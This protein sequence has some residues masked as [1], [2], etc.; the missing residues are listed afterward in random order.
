MKYL[1]YDVTAGAGD[2][3]VVTLSHAANVRLLDSTNFQQFRRGKRHQYL[4]G[5][6]RVSPVRLMV[7][8]HGHWHV[9]VDLGGIPGSVRAS[10]AIERS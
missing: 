9:V 10:V 2:T 7:P 1:N 8:R 5:H 6:A 3:V 4:G